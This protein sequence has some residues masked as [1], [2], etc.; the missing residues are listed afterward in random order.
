MIDVNWIALGVVAGIVV[1]AIVV[2]SIAMWTDM[3][4]EISTNSKIDYYVFTKTVP[5]FYGLCGLR[6]DTIK[7]Y[8]SHIYDHELDCM[9]S[10]EGYYKLD[11]YKLESIQYK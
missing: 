1:I 10:A 11:G 2:T 4:R 5:S 6:V 3:Q 8:T 7:C 9:T